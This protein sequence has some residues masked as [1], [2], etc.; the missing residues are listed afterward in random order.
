M[1]A[2]APYFLTSDNYDELFVSP[3]AIDFGNA[4][5]DENLAIW[6]EDHYLEMLLGFDVWKALKADLDDNGDPQTAKYEYLVDGIA[7]GWTDGDYYYPLKGI[8]AMLKN[9]YY[10]EYVKGNASHLMTTGVEEF[11]SANSTQSGK[12]RTLKMVTVWNE[13]VKYYRELIAYIEYQNGQTA[14]TYEN[15]RYIELQT[16]NTFG[17]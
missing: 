8:T 6:V 15:H 13:A 3:I 9:F 5:F 2:S 10:Y 4:G 7:A 14:D 12:G 11:D 17:I 1:A 16:A